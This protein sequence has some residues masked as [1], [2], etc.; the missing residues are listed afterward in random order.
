MIVRLPLAQYGY[1]QKAIVAMLE[2]S[3]RTIRNW[4]SG[5]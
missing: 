3:T 4:K 2:V 1:S 5:K